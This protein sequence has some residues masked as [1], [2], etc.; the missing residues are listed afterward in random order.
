MKWNIP[1]IYVRKNKIIPG[2]I[3]LSANIKYK[4]TPAR[5]MQIKEIKNKF[6]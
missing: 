3:F 2:R 1:K 5:M 4:D 6:Q